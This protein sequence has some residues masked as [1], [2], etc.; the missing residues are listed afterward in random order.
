MQDKI[1]NWEKEWEKGGKEGLAVRYY[2]SSA[3]KQKTLQLSKYRDADDMD[4]AL[5]QHYDWHDKWYVNIW[6]PEKTFL[7]KT[8]KQAVAFA[9]KYMRSH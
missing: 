3:K 2:N 6:Y 4:K 5:N 8:E 1:G 7:F 9:I